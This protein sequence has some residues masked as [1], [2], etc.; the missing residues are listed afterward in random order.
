MT[1][2]PDRNL[3]NKSLH[4]VRVPLLSIPLLFAFGCGGSNGGGG[5]PPSNPT[6]TSVSASCAPSSIQTSQTS[7]CS[8][9]VSGTGSYSSAVTW[10]ATGGTITSAGIFTPSGTGT[11][12]ITAT[13][14]QDTTK[15]GTASIA[16]TALT[17][18]VPTVTA[19][20][21]P[22]LTV[23]AAPQP[24]TINGTGF[25]SSSTVTFN[26]IAHTAAYVS[27]SQLTISLTTADLATVGIY[28]VVVTNPAPGGG[29]SSP[30]NFTVT[31]SSS[32]NAEW[33]W[34]TGS[35]TGGG[36]GV[37]GSLGVSS[38]SNVP[39][40]R[41]GATSWTD[42][43]GNLW[44][45]GGYGVN[46]ADI[47]GYLNDL[48]EYSPAAKTWTWVAGANTPNQTGVYGTQG[49]S[50]TSNAPGARQSAVGWMDGNGNLWLFGGVTNSAGSTGHFN[51]LW[52]YN[53]TAKTW[54][55]IA[56]AS[57]SNQAGVYGTQGTP[58]TMNAPG[59]RDSAA[60]WI[61][62]K[63]NLWCFGGYGVDSTGSIGYLNDLWEFSPTAKTWTWVSGA[64]TS[65]QTGV[66]GTQ[67][68]PATTNAPGARYQAASWID[69]NGN[70]WLFGGYALD[71]K[72][73]DDFFND[74]WEFNPTAKT[75]TWVAGANTPNE[76]G[77]Y[78]TQGTPA[79]TNVP[80]ARYSAVTWTD[81][82]NN[83]WLFGGGAGSSQKSVFFSDLW[84]FNPTTKTWTWVNGPDMPNQPGAYGTQGT[85]A[86]TNIPGGRDFAVGWIDGGGNFW[87][88]GGD[89][90]DS[91]GL[92]WDL[93]DLWRFQSTIAPP[94]IT[95]VS[96]T[97]SP[98]SILTTQT[99]TCTPTVAGT[100]G[101]STSVMWSVSPTSMGSVS[102]AGVFT[103]SAA[104]T[105]TITATSAQDTT[106][107]GTATVTAAEP[108]AITSVAVSCIMVSVPIGQSDQC[109][110]IVSGTGSFNSSVSWSVDGISGG[111]S[112][113]GTISATGLYTAPANL[114]T[115]FTVTVTATSIVNST[116]AASVPVV[117]A[118]TIA[119]VSQSI[120]AA[121][122]GTITL[123]D[124]SSV[125]IP[126][127][128]LS[129]DEN[130]TLSELSA[131]P[132]EPPNQMFVGVGTALSLSFSTPVQA[133][134]A[135]GKP[136]YRKDN[137]ALSSLATG[138]STPAFAFT[139]NESSTTLGLANATGT[140]SLTDNN[141]NVAFATVPYSAESIS[142]QPF[143]SLSL[144]SSS[145]ADVPNPVSSLSISAIN[146]RTAATGVTSGSAV[147]SVYWCLDSTTPNNPKW[148]PSVSCP[149]QTNGEKVLI[150][151]HG[152][153][154][155]INET[156]PSQS[157]QLLNSWMGSKNYDLVVGLDY[158][159]T[160]KL[161]DS[162]GIIKS[163]L[164]TVVGP[165]SP[166][167]ID[168]V[169][170]SEGVPVSLYGASESSQAAHI[171]NFVGLAGPI[172]GTPVVNASWPLPSI[173][174]LK[175][176][177]SS[178]WDS[179]LIG[180]ELDSYSQNSVAPPFQTDLAVNSDALMNKMLPLAR[181]NL[182]STRIIL[183][184][185]TNPTFDNIDFDELGGYPFGISLISVVTG[186]PYY[187]TPNDGFVGLDSALAFNSGLVVYPLPT[188]QLN[189]FHTDL[190]NTNALSEVAAQL[191]SSTSPHLK[192][193][194]SESPDC[195]GP[196]DSTFSF[197]GSGF[198]TPSANIEIFS[199]D[200]SGTIT[201]LQPSLQ[202]V[203]GDIS[204]ASTPTCSD[205][206]ETYSVFGFDSLENLAS[207]NAIELITGGCG[208][209]N[210]VP[211]IT[212]PFIPASLPVGSAP[213][214]LTINGTG[215]LAS[216]TATY[217]G[218]AHTTT[219]VSTSQITIS[220]T[221]ADLATVGSFPVVVSNPAPGGGASGPVNFTVTSNSS[222]SSVWTW[223][224]G[225]STAGAV[226]VY[227]SLGVPSTSNVPG[228][229]EGAVTWTDA[230]GNLWIFGGDSTD[231]NGSFGD[232]NDL[233]K[234]NP[235]AVT[236]TWISGAN[237]RGQVGVYGVQGSPAAANVPGARDS[238]ASWTDSNGNLW[239]FGGSYIDSSRNYYLLNDLW[240][241]APAA[242]EWTWVSGSNSSF[243][244][245]IYGT[246]GLPA[247]PNVP[248][249][250]EEA[251]TWID[252]G[253]NLWLFGGSGVDS[254]G[255][256]SSLND[257][258]EFNPTS[259]EWTWVSGGNTVDQNGV[260]GTQGV[261]ATTNVPE[262][263]YGST[264]WV[265]ANGNLWLFGGFSL[266]SS[267]DSG[268][269]NDLWEFNP[270]VN[271]WTWVS[272]A[273]T[274]SQPG[275]YGTKGTPAMTNVPGARE[276]TLS[277]I[278]G[279]GKFWLFGGTGIDSTGTLGSLNDLWEFNPS[280]KM[281]TWVS[282][283]S[284][285]NQ[286]GIYGTQGIPAQVNIPGARSQAASWIDFS[287]NIWLFGGL[288]IDSTGS[289]WYLNDL[290][291]FQ[292]P[293][294]TP[295]TLNPTP[296]ING[297]MPPFLQ[298]GSSPQELQ[299]NGTGFLPSSVV[300]FNGVSHTPTY[301]NS[302]L[303]SIELAAADL[304]TIGNFPVVVTNPTPGG[305]M[306]TSVFTV[307][308]TANGM[309][310]SPSAVTVPA[311]AT[312]TFIASAPGGGT[313]T[314]AVQEGGA[315]GAVTSAGIYAAP[316]TT[317]TFHVVATNSANS[318]QTAT[319]TVTVVAATSY[320][321]TSISSINGSFPTASLVQGSDGNLYGTSAA[322]AFRLDSSFSLTKLASLPGSIY[323]PISTLIQASDGNFY[324]VASGGD[325]SIFKMNSSGNV[326]TVYSF[327]SPI[328]GTIS[329]LWP[330][331]GLI[332]GTD[333][334]L[335][336]TT[337][338]GGN[339]SCKPYGY[340]LPA[341]GPFNYNPGAG[342][343]C[344]TIY[345]MDASGNVAI[346][347]SFS[348]QSDGNFP[349]APLIQGSDGNFYGTTSGGGTY[350]YGTVFKIS[351]LGSLETLHSFSSSNGDAPVAALIQASDGNLYGTAACVFCGSI[352]SSF[353]GEVFKIDTSGNNF[354]VLHH[355]SGPDGSLPVAPLIQ[356]SDGDFYG[357]TWAGGDLTC[358]S[359]YFYV[360]SNYPYVRLG[361][362]GTVFRMD[363]VGN[364]T[365]LHNFEEPQSGD[366]NDPY[367]G[368][369]L[370]KDGYLYGTT[371]YGGTSIYFGTVF[372]LGVPSVQ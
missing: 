360:G 206:I 39:G 266:S 295:P 2:Q 161:S 337:Y 283:S 173:L 246:Q 12:T 21:P 35:N 51:D 41:V 310:I 243:Q 190:T 87:L 334:N 119:S 349:Q 357:T 19:L 268:Y 111:N 361:G 296:A 33:A 364:I 199:Q 341:Y 217:N 258:W 287:G 367:S 259:Q 182:G 146:T 164:E 255:I 5:N 157:A 230:Q 279:S 143:A 305:G 127:N 318:A 344:G 298:V 284:F 272:G 271:S 27:A 260:F 229:R 82:N 53:P 269:I 83:F 214:A 203:S 150:L 52:E 167:R 158:D 175:Y 348:G 108:P 77:V 152:M 153:M 234:F 141:G 242:N 6:I 105:A 308:S 352:G 79:T 117:I 71:S 89:G 106:K 59:A 306:A 372:R 288:G 92:T 202:D 193:S 100:E 273:N 205:P 61:D 16:V 208:T 250:R 322:D 14:T 189:L 330:W 338:A 95:S 31:S 303:L 181:S 251:V 232:F 124:G 312:Q 346:L 121:S 44:L 325:G 224:G 73:N 160:G 207:N 123:P 25:L 249:A 40:E 66:Y 54:T 277:W 132:Q 304:S 323:A 358:G 46:Q 15:F 63:G 184:G 159:W 216:S 80:G 149:T 32:S 351:P 166:S 247:P 320:T 156:F 256:I 110:A 37:Y 307:S 84:E 183:A 371:Y 125:I 282:G 72:G 130:V 126:A 4:F 70:L 115:P 122:G 28:P 137:G 276:G 96:V 36:S 368:L 86:V 113:F 168:I 329:G 244:S 362:C 186:L 194:N 23:G 192:C 324:G 7:Q 29:P 274:S 188:F 102:N 140:A 144:S 354:T 116:V 8:A 286:S 335:Y 24:L 336:G 221:T 172:L 22:S 13:S 49:V 74:I 129:A 103:P 94:T 171:A 332:Q 68:T 252:A 177:F 356:G 85:P 97:C 76:A 281:W 316:S 60:S 345:K 45:F 142:S 220:L 280:T 237:S 342:D 120:S 200:P 133:A 321:A 187:P 154:S 262:S 353:T 339:T 347:Y 291:R 340:G 228:E 366:G 301:S 3:P 112:T 138:N 299:I 210:P 69:S 47:G 300:T 136:N 315:G 293:S 311:G 289:S 204:W 162:A 223:M 90:I 48:W 88:F 11:A 145:L 50:A 326:T 254:D 235:S 212:P 99:S 9:T 238:A 302:G 314:W 98:A 42:G 319:A 65:N 239:L 155:C 240:R 55:W 18:P 317:G 1:F 359:W 233:W 20:L 93:N 290:W 104:G 135:K 261:P 10:S 209:S 278:D 270:A 236:W 169:A 109:S 43:N 343:G 38:A 263:R 201:T 176:D 294:I 114:P 62:G 222:G 218:I 180:H 81:G 107:F 17:N 78:G 275:V 309:I 350:G 195:Q 179:G 118:G 227:G 30:V 34:V 191:F 170:H 174:E 363:S 331:A 265:D 245:G 151:V 257:L 131:L 328:S 370:G 56:G 57:T 292:S 58:A 148:L 267:N 327:P 139:I 219:Y 128:A 67:G 64:N 365:V 213:Q 215:F 165:Y 26:G 147:P 225:S 211:A 185:G 369:L 333:G 197:S 355:F 163:F 297:L 226:G 198:S 313:V 134:S 231:L 241:F 248:G 101:Y 253:G 285:A 264:G 178:C 91:T 196:L 75:W